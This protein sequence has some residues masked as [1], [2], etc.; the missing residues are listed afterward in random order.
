MP[1]KFAALT[2]AARDLTAF[3]EL[4]S[5]GHFPEAF[6]EKE[7]ARL[8]RAV[9]VADEFA[10]AEQRDDNAKSLKTAA[11]LRAK[12]EASVDSTT[13]L[14]DLTEHRSL[15][16][17]PQ[18]GDQL[19]AKSR[20]MLR[21]NQPARARVYLEAAIS[22]GVRELGL[23]GTIVDVDDALDASGLRFDA[24]TIEE[25]A[26]RADAA[27]RGARLRALADSGVGVTADGSAGHGHASEAASAN[28]GAK[29]A[30]YFGGQRKFPVGDNSNPVVGGAS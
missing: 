15:V 21:A 1:S 16:E 18:N 11:D 22:K 3:R 12:A 10:S 25:S 8:S 29:V 27:F 17:G 14:A 7:T 9:Q 6:V 24:R 20:E 28:L 19:L 30:D 13:R 2:Q 26:G 4:S 23:H 5:D